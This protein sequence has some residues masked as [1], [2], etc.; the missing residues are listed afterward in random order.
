M[1]ALSRYLL[2]LYYV[3]NALTHTGFGELTGS[4]D[5]E[6]LLT[7][8]MLFATTFVIAYLI[9]E[10]TL[11]LASLVAT[12][13]HYQHKLSV[14]ENHF[15]TLGISYRKI[16]EVRHYFKLLWCRCRGMVYFNI[17]AELPYPL[18]ADM[19]ME[20]YGMNVRSVGHVKGIIIVC[21]FSGSAW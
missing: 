1:S 7:I 19:A 21:F 4:T 17:M 14:L 13:I 20:I 5:A 10:M 9:G 8:V 11:C 15:E 16:E 6:L 3:T 18:R 2:S 12:K